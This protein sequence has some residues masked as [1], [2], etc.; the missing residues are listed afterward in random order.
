MTDRIQELAKKCY[1][2]GPLTR[3]GWPE[4]TTFD[5]KKFADLLIKE[6]IQSIRCYDASGHLEHQ[7]R[8]H[9]DVPR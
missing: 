2:T 4:Y 1:Q 6:C 9:F 8:E 5:E 7:I 3:D